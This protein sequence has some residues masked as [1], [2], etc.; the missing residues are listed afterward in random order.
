VTALLENLPRLTADALS[1]MDS[2][3]QPPV[4]FVLYFLLVS[5][6]IAVVSSA[7]RIREPR[8]IIGEAFRFF[9]YIVAGIALF[10]V[11]VFILEQL[12]V[13]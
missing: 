11:V 8:R 1:A 4:P 6:V 12:F 7:I 5:L 9:V 2:V 3:P 10:S 13:R